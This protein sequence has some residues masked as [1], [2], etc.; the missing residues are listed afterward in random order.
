MV[1]IDPLYDNQ[2]LGMLNMSSNS[3]DFANSTQPQVYPLRLCPFIQLW[4]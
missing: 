1:H 3:A 2:M 4:V